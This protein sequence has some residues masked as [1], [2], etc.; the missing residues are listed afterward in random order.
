MAKDWI[1]D[2]PFNW[3]RELGLWGAEDDEGTDDEDHFGESGSG[4]GSGISGGDHSGM[5][6]AACIACRL[7]LYY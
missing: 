7:L 4:S 2:L 3:L 1:D 6:P 5:L